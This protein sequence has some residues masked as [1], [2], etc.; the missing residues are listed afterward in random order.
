M[1]LLP[2][3]EGTVREVTTGCDQTTVELPLLNTMGRERRDGAPAG[4]HCQD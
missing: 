2:L 3:T 1:P 4:K